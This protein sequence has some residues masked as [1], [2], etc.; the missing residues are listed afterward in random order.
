MSK[1]SPSSPDALPAS[2]GE[3]VQQLEELIAGLESGQLPLEQLLGQY[4]RGTQLLKYCRDSLQSVE[5]QVRVLD[6][7][8]G[9]KPWVSE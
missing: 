8:G 2:Y 5:E 7:Q 6:E 9:L 3:A 4:Q 1:K